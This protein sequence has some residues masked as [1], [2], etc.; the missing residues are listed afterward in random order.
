MPLQVHRLQELTLAGYT[1]T[2]CCQAATHGLVL[3]A[4]SCAASLLVQHTAQEALQL[5]PI[6]L[7]CT[8]GTVPHTYRLQL[9][10]HCWPMSKA[11]LNTGH[12]A[13]VATLWPHTQLS[14]H[15]STAAAWTPLL[16]CQMQ[17]QT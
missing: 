17:F 14:A 8:R 11:A 5:L 3:A 4:A 7:H 2:H 16:P 15:S 12:S 1:Y 9:W 13:T 6:S 10:K